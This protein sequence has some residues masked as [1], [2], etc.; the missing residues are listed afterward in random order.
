M[1][2]NAC[3][4]I[5][6]DLKFELFGSLDLIY[7]L[8]DLAFYTTKIELVVVMAITVILSK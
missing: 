7:T 8:V 6:Q 5:K 3:R 4:F 1:Q 2:L